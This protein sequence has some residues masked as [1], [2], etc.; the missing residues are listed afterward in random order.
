MYVVMCD[1]ITHGQLIY[2]QLCIVHAGVT[3]IDLLIKINH[4]AHFTLLPT[5]PSP[6]IFV[7]LLSWS[8]KL[9]EPLNVRCQISFNRLA[10]PAQ[11]Q[12]V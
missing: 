7:C 9:D 8:E 2:D 6:N 3:L 11:P 10:H 1:Y 4:Y 12:L 5:Q